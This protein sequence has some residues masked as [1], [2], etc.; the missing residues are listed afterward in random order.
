MHL[1]A[2]IPYVAELATF[3][4]GVHVALSLSLD[5]DHDHARARHGARAQAFDSVSGKMPIARNKHDFGHL[6]GAITSVLPL[7][8]A[9]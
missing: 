9:F 1:S 6:K 3:S 7:R 5:V 4:L 8:S 2:N